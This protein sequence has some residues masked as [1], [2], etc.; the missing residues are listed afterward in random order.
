MLKNMLGDCWK[1]VKKKRSRKTAHE[2][3]SYQ[4]GY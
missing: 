3:N 1:D 2:L 4:Q